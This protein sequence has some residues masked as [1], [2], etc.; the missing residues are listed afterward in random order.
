[1]RRKIVLILF[2][3][4]L[5]PIV[6]LSGAPASEIGSSGS[7]SLAFVGQDLQ[8][9]GQ[10]LMSYQP[11]TG[12][13]TLVFQDGFS[14]SIGA[15]QFS[16]DNAVVRLESVMVESHE[17]TRIDYEAKVYLEG[18]ITVTKGRGA[19]TSGISQV[20]IEEG[21][22][23]VVRFGVSGEVFVTAEKREM[24]TGVCKL[25]LCKKAVAAFER[26]EP[27]IVI[28]PEAQVPK[29]QPKVVQPKKPTEKPVTGKPTEKPVKPTEVVIKP[30]A[31]KP[32]FTYPVNIS[33]AGEAPLNVESTRA[34]DETEIA[35]VIGRFYLWQKQNEKGGLLELQADNAVVFYS[36]KV[37]GAGKDS[38][39]SRPQADLR[40][41]EKPQ[42]TGRVKELMA[43]G[44]VRAIYVCGDVVMTEGQRTIRADEM[45]YDFLR[46]KALAINGEMK[47]FDAKRGIPIYVRAA[48]FRQLAENKFAAENVTLTSSEFHLPQ[49]SL[50]A[51]SIVI[52]DTTPVDQQEGKVSNSSYDAQMRDVRL[53]MYDRTI[54]YWPF[55]RSNLQRPDTPLKSIRTGYDSKWG[56]MVETRWYLARL[57]GLREPEGTNSTYALDYYGKR[58]LGTGAMINYAKRNYFGSILGYVIH[59][60]GEDDL[61]RDDSRRNIEPPH[62]LR[63]RFRWLHRHF[64]PYNWQLTSEISYASDENF[65][66]GYYRSEYDVGKEQETL[67]HLKRIEDNW[68]LSI[69]GKARINN[70]VNKVEELPTIEHHLVGQSL[71]NDKLTFYNDSQFSRFRNR[72]ASKRGRSERFFTF[73][74][75]RAELDLPMRIGRSKVVPF[76]ASTIGYDDGSGFQTNIDGTATESEDKVWSGEGGVR[77]SLQPY[78]K[79]YPNIRSRLWDLNG[80]RHIIKPYA[81]AVKY[82]DSDS[83]IEQRDVLNIGISQRLQTKRGPGSKRR[84]VDWMRLDMEFTWVSDTDEPSSAGPGPDRFIWNK[85]FV[86]L[87]DP[88]SG[89]APLLDRRS[90]NIFGPRRNYFGADYLWR[91]SDTTALLSDMNYDLQSDVVQQFNIGF[92]HLRWPNLSYYIGSRYLRRLDNGLGE[93]GSNMFTFAATYVLDPRYTMVFSQQFDFDYGANVRSDITLIRRYHRMYWGL[94][95]SADESLKE[96]SIIFS[97]WPQGVPEMS[98]GSRKYMELGGSPGY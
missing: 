23:M 7:K 39:E 18:A 9:R 10:R 83:S 70:F 17:R 88:F 80:L 89:Q 21:R 58:G 46:K 31:K 20:V 26:S 73:M 2:F 75:D 56:A 67:V 28:R 29:W 40:R 1:M 68:G 14:M 91:I 90:S 30:K 61:G 37:S 63:G 93:K 4:V 71:F 52:A 32:S 95:Y 36:G 77:A 92:S 15:N 22:S 94:T 51:S 35:T 55:L 62:K 65:I 74:S 19:R 47:S 50:N 49:I 48:K 57:L 43:K 97:V 87:V 85:P 69:L 66:E 44:N 53:K 3:W 60:T 25:E 33:P 12:E 59:D 11:S 78:W 8:L 98:F 16:S 42:G 34:V 64:L 86:P 24:L 45:Y 54:F 5:L 27:K 82:T 6:R 79:V 13:Y 41:T 38:A 84:T 72:F 76:V 96:H 81:T